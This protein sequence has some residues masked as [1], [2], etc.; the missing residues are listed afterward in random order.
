MD[1][2]AFTLTALDLEADGRA[3]ATLTLTIGDDAEPGA[4]DLDAADATVFLR[5][6][7][8]ERQVALD[9][10]AVGSGDSRQV[11]YGAGDTIQLRAAGELTDP[12]GAGIEEAGIVVTLDAEAV[13]A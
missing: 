7:A 8:A 12:P 6:G 9:L 1:I 5:A 2:Q 4:L 10:S 13:A 11:A 3:E